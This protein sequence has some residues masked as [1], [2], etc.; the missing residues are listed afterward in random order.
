MRFFLFIML[1]VSCGEDGVNNTIIDAG[2]ETSGDVDSYP[3]VS[4]ED[5]IVPIL[6]NSCILDG[7]HGERGVSAFLVPKGLDATPEEIKLGVLNIKSRNGNLLIAPGQPSKSE[8]LIRI[9]AE[10]NAMPPLTTLPIEQINDLNF[11]VSQMSIPT[12]N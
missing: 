6:R 2:N 10:E 4:F 9:L 1:L 5:E 11:W 8:L 7:C 12:N 3:I